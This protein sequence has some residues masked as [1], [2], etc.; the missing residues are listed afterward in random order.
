[1]TQ[2]TTKGRRLR[3]IVAIVA[4]AASA[5]MGMVLFPGAAHASCVAPGMAGWRTSLTAD[6]V[7]AFDMAVSGT[8]NANTTYRTVL[9]SSSTDWRPSIWFLENGIW[10]VFLGDK[11]R[12]VEIEYDD[13]DTA[14]WFHLCLDDGTTWRCGVGGSFTQSVGPTHFIHGSSAGY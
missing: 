14:S 12:P 9:S 6:G 1:M 10:L 7:V 2:Q 8:C 13:T 11:T 5:A 4:L 3:A